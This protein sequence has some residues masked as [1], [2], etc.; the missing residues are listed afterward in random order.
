MCVVGP[1]FCPSKSHV[2]TCGG[3]C[4]FKT[5]DSSYPVFWR[6]TFTALKAI[7][8]RTDWPTGGSASDSSSVCLWGLT[9]SVTSP[10]SP[11]FS[12]AR[13]DGESSCA[14]AAPQDQWRVASDEWQAKTPEKLNEKMRS[15]LAPPKHP[16][17]A[18][19]C[20]NSGFF[21]PSK[22]AALGTC[23]QAPLIRLSIDDCRLP[24]ELDQTA[25]GEQ[26]QHNPKRDSSPAYAGSE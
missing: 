22:K 23:E 12:R 20:F 16:E 18:K 26:Y 1:C 9:H 4:S 6:M 24:I 7:D 25:P 19:R 5:P 13:R 8:Q 15:F 10:F 2:H 3:G 11:L 21:G 14:L 17:A